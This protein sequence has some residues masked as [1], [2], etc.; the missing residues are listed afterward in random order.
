MR[1]AAKGRDQSPLSL[2]PTLKVTFVNP[3]ILLITEQNGFINSPP[4]ETTRNVT[5]PILSNIH[6]EICGAFPY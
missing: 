5:R 1:E 6:G 2:R 4:F 3:P